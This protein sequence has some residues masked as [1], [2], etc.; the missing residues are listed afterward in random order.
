MNQ[1]NMEE[2]KPVAQEPDYVPYYYPEDLHESTLSMC[3]CGHHDG[4]HDPQTQVRICKYATQCGCTG[5]NW[6]ATKITH[7]SRGMNLG[8]AIIYWPLMFVV[9]AFLLGVG[10]VVLFLL[11]Q[12][13]HFAWNS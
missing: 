4:Y 6:D 13:I 1:E 8:E 9:Y 11:V 10:L 3:V 7:E 12:F 5:W 2:T